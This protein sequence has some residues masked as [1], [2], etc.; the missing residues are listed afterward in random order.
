MCLGKKREL[1]SLLRRRFSI[2]WPYGAAALDK[3]KEGDDTSFSPFDI[4]CGVAA[5]THVSSLQILYMLDPKCL[6]Q[7]RPLSPSAALYLLRYEQMI[8]HVSKNVFLFSLLFLRSP[9][10]KTTLSFA[11]FVF[12]PSNE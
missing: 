11:D 10:N 4:R 2:V 6:Q 8:S 7:Q 12:L 1:R 3:A 5:I 9:V